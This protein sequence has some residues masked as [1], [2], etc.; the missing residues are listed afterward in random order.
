MVCYTIN[1]MPPE[2]QSIKKMILPI[3]KKSGVKRSAVFGSFARGEATNKSDIDLL[4]ELPKGTSLL[5]LIHLGHLLED[6]LGRDVDVIT[7]TS[8]YKPLRERILN[9]S[10]RI[11]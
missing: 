2:I 1:I 8:I 4:V 11:L 5:D 9:E 6:K 3:L 10:I 7:Y